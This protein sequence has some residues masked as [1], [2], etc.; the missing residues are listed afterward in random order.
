MPESSSTVAEPTLTWRFPRAFWTA[1]SVELFERAAYYGTF[2]ALA[3]YLTDVV[4]FSDV[5]AGWIGAGFASG[6]YLLPFITGAAADR[7]G[8]RPSL[9]LAF[10]LLAAGYGSLGFF[11]SKGPV[12][13]AL[14]L[15]VVG[16]SFV[17]PIITGTVAKS[18][19]ARNRARA[20][21]LFYMIVN[22][23]SFR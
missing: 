1:N 10:A 20:Y 16:G 6:I 19:D 11:P 14:L 12:L 2:I 9:L 5:Q 17:K 18:S 15:I 13:S 3:L 22:I 21:S 23:G 8:F 7:I 4:G